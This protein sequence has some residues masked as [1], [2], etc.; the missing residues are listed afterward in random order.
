VKHG[1]DCPNRCSMCLGAPARIVS[2]DATTI[3]GQPSGRASDPTITSRSYYA[4]RGGQA[5]GRRTHQ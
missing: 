4:R 3:D 2:V 5:K 1:R